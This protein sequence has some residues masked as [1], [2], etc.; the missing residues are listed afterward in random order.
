VYKSETNLNIPDAIVNN[1]AL[2][3][4]LSINSRI[5]LIIGKSLAYIKEIEFVAKQVL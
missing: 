2:L 5:L 4:G 1:A 3:L